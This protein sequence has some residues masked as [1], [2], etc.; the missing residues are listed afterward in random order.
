MDAFE[1]RIRCLE[2]ASDLYGSIGAPYTAEALL[3]VADLMWDWF[4][5]IA[6]DEPA[7]AEQQPITETRQ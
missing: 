2:I 4:M 5:A 7:S 6:E 1:A 3:S